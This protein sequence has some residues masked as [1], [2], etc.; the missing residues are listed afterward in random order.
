VHH[1]TD[2]TSE[3][4]KRSVGENLAVA[5]TRSVAII[6]NSSILSSTDSG[7]HEMS[8]KISSQAVKRIWGVPCAY[9]DFL[10]VT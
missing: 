10:P 3:S 9:K 7:L 5:S 1:V 2:F 4:P 6:S 8:C